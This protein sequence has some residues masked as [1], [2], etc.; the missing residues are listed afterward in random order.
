M[1]D[2]LEAADRGAEWLDGILPGWHNYVNP[3]QLDIAKWA[4][5]VI[6]QLSALGHF[7]PGG[8]YEAPKPPGFIEGSERYTWE[9][10]GI[11]CSRGE[12]DSLNDRW[13]AIIQERRA[14]TCR[15]TQEASA[16]E[17]E[18]SPCPSQEVPS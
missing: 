11:M 17:L 7:P 2:C 16:L 5:C 12:T 18:A 4:T 15:H 3:D 14:S 13:R 6:G 8:L 10:Y 1:S 9:H